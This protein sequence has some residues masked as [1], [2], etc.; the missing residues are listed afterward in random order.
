MGNG[1]PIGACPH[2]GQPLNCSR[3]SHG[4]T[5]AGNPG[6][7]GSRPA[8]LD[9]IEADGLLA[10]SRELGEHLAQAMAALGHPLVAGVR[11]RGLLRGIELT[12]EVG[13]RRGRAAGRGLDHQ[14]AAPQRPAA[15]PPLVI[16]DEA[17]DFAAALGEA[18]DSIQ[19]P[20]GDE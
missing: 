12:A 2:L 8:V 6:G 7:G 17:I 16:T 11:G 5:F 18:L 13:P 3:P 4:S 20:A 14:C 9:T 10:R 1:I 19:P 15:A